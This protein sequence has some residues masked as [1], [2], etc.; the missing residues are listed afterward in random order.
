MT[1]KASK[2]MRFSTR[3]VG[4]RS[5]G[6]RIGRQEEE[7][8]G[9]S[10]RDGCEREARGREARGKMRRKGQ[11]KG[12][13]GGK[14]VKEGGR[15]GGR[16]TRATYP[17]VGN[18]SAHASEDL[19]LEGPRSVGRE[20][21]KVGQAWAKGGQLGGSMHWRQRGKMGGCRETTAR[22]PQP[23]SVLSLSL[24]PSLPPSLPTCKTWGG[25]SPAS[26]PTSTA[27]K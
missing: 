25:L 4:G 10:V 22:S 5:W 14:D 9:G 24:P 12:K 23:R 18:P 3:S 1:A 11:K 13:W 7:R 16:D 2:R 26:F 8:E 19:S 20:E 21:E 6:G 27:A 17:V 15:E